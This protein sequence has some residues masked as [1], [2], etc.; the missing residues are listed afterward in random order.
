LGL[1][2]GTSTPSLIKTPSALRQVRAEYPVT[3]ASSAPL[4]ADAPGTSIPAAI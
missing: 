2:P 1:A 4:G 3:R